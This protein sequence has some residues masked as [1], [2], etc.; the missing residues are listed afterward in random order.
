MNISNNW[1]HI[2]W[3]KFLYI[4][5]KQFLFHKKGGKSL[6]SIFILVYLPANLPWFQGLQSFAGPLGQQMIFYIVSD[7]LL[8]LWPAKYL[9]FAQMSSLYCCSL[10][11]IIK[12]FVW[13]RDLL[14]TRVNMHPHLATTRCYYFKYF[15]SLYIENMEY[16]VT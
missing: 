16:F 7:H 5:S 9:L 1:Y 10:Y 14:I 15:F 13:P 8:A 4:I 12:D 3:S 2:K 11:G 6:I